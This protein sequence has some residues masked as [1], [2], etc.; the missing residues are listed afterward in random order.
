MRR[1][2]ARKRNA[3]SEQ[4]V[5]DFLGIGIG[6]FGALMQSADFFQC[7]GDAFGLPGELHGA[8]IGQIFALTA[9]AG[10]DHATEKQTDIA[11]DHQT[12]RHT[13]NRSGVFAAETTVFENF[14]AD[15]CH[16]HDAEQQAHQF[17]V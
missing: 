6:D 4:H 3:G 1:H 8:G 13:D 2:H 14:L 10:L 11:D 9:D 15:Q 16:H 5:T 7:T 12:E 17:D